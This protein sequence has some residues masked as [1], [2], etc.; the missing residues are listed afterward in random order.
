MNHEETSPPRVTTNV[1]SVIQT[2]FVI[3]ATSVT[4][5]HGNIN[6]N[7]DY[8][9]NNKPSAQNITRV[10]TN[11]DVPLTSRENTKNEFGIENESDTICRESTDQDQLNENPKSKRKSAIILG[12]SMI[13]H[14]KEWEI[15]KKLKLECKVFVKTFPGATTQCVADYMKPLRQMI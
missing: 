7:K 14:K 8:S 12:D 15:A 13:K 9:M 1:S 6:M 4:A 11:P 10:I 2:S 5:Q 3:P